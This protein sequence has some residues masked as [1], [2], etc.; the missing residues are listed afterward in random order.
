MRRPAPF[1]LTAGRLTD[2]AAFSPLFSSRQA[3]KEAESACQRRSR[4][5][6]ES[7]PARPGA[8]RRR[9]AHALLN[10]TPYPFDAPRADPATASPPPPI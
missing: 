7:G 4:P 6:L 1:P 5:A 9:F 2:L 10:P 3:R 8:D